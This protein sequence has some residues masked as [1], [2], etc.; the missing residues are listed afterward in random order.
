MNNNN[1]NNKLPMVQG[2]KPFPEPTPAAAKQVTNKPPMA[3]NKPPMAVNQV[4]N[5]KVNKPP[6]AVN[7]VTN[8]KVN[9]PTMAAK[10]ATNVKVNNPPMAAKQVTNVKVNKPALPAKPATNVKV[11]NPPMAAKQVKKN[12]QVNKPV[13]N[14]KKPPITKNNVPLVK[15]SNNVKVN[16]LSNAVNNNNNK[17]N[18]NFKPKKRKQTD[19][20]VKA[21]A[22]V[23]GIRDNVKDAMKGLSSLNVSSLSGITRLTKLR[24]WGFIFLISIILVGI[25]ILAKFIIVSYYTYTDKGPYLI[26]G[27]KTASHAV[28]ISQD[29][30]SINYIPIQRSENENGIEF[31]Y[32]FWALYMDTNL[33]NDSNNDKWKHIFHKGNSTSYPNRAPGA[34]FFPRENKMRIYMNTF[35]NPLEHLDISNI[36]IKKWFHCSIVLQNKLSHLDDESELYNKS[37]NKN[38]I[39]D[40]YI[41]GKLKKS[42]QLDGVP[43]QNNGDVYVNLFNGFDGYLSKFRYLNRAVQFAELD[44]IIKEGPSKVVTEDTGTIPE[45]LD[46]EW[47]FSGDNSE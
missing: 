22:A 7:Q 18:N 21:K 41:N 19:I 40:I 11:N 8:V 2:K 32:M 35:N 29:P 16:K 17:N 27:T 20:K 28:I 14:T 9:K 26:E 30:E 39:L 25:I 12:N 24:K 45:Y 46:E 6:M 43:K 47:W 44:S 23:A 33:R 13:I 4:T 3:A 5:A 38:H 15:T 36:P 42:K 1:N 34:W 31:T 37:D 10:P